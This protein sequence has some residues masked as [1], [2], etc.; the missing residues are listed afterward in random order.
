MINILY[1]IRKGDINMEDNKIEVELRGFL[2]TK[3]ERWRNLLIE[4]Q[5]F[6]GMP[7][8]TDELVIFFK[9]DKDIR[10]K[11]TKDG[12]FIIWKERSEK[13]KSKFMLKEHIASISMDTVIDFVRIL[14]AIGYK[15]GLFSYCTR[16]D[17]KK[18]P[19]SFSI[20]LN[21][22]CGD[23]FEIDKK[24]SNEKQIES[25]KN[26]LKYILNKLKLRPWT[27]EEYD[28]HRKRSW[29]NVEKERLIY[30]DGTPNVKIKNIVCKYQNK[31]HQSTNESVLERLKKGIE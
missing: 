2:P 25:A 12:A 16:Y 1:N 13:N 27:D 6:W 26:E 29:S 10:L 14:D 7:S 17:Y 19:Y 20:K 15:E 30:S 9:Y 3:G 22:V 4:L 5:K 28:R 23:F 8:V 11:I 21:S 18:G 31:T 24:I